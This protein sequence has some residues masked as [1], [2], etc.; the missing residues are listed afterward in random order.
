MISLLL[1]A[2]AGVSLEN[3]NVP[4]GKF[5]LLEVLGGGQGS[6]AGRIVNDETAKAISA[7]WS[8]VTTISASVGSLPLR[9]VQYRADMRTKDL[10][11]DHPLVYLL[12][13]ES[14]PGVSAASYKES[15]MAHLLLRGNMV[16]DAVRQRLSRELEALFLLDP[17]RYTV[18]RAYP[19]S[20]TRY[21]P[22]V[23]LHPTMQGEEG[24]VLGPGRTFRISGVGGDGVVG[25]SVIKYGRET[26]GAALG[27]EDYGARFFANDATPRGVLQHP[28]ALSKEAKDA[29]RNHWQGMYGGSHNSHRV[30]VLEEGMEFQPIQMNAEDTQFMESR[31]FTVREVARWFNIPPHKIADMADAK[32]ANIDAQNLEYLQDTL[33]PWLTRWRQA[34]TAQLLDDDERGR[35]RLAVEWDFRDL[36]RGDVAARTA[37]YQARFNTGSITPNEIR[38]EE[39]ENPLEGGDQAFVQRQYVPLDMVQ[40]VTEAGLTGPPA[41]PPPPAGGQD[42]GGEEE[43]QRQLL[44]ERARKLIPQGRQ[45]RAFDARLSLREA[46][47]PDFR[48]RAGRMVRG[49]LRELRK[50]KKRHL[51]G[52]LVDVPAWLESVDE[53]YRGGFVPFATEQLAAGFQAYAEAVRFQ[54][55]DEAPEGSPDPAPTQ[56]ELREFTEGYTEAAVNGIAAGGRRR[57]QQLAEQAQE[58]EEDPAAAVEQELESWAGDE[59]GTNGRAER[60]ATRHVNELNQAVAGFI[61]AA[62]NVSF[63]VA[64]TVGDSCP[65]CNAIDGTRVAP[66]ASFFTAGDELQPE[67]VNTPLRFNST[68]RHPPFHQG[69]DCVITPEL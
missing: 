37:Y 16:T 6:A 38:M 32:W 57:M 55:E 40:K 64:R 43:D 25:W 63:L 20:S 50:L 46:F 42:E 29:L 18:K 4:L 65:Y 41:A 36:L 11:L 51:E 23:L 9:V 34:I 45:R 7:V 53:Y 60:V 39:G 8:A 3:P 21:I 47:R 14:S 59:E 2:R 35:D 66:G 69:C 58:R 67:G 27:Q 49:E 15:S 44:L 24:R 61:W 5:S 22:V 19:V 54:A 62:M 10:V 33:T 68:V 26:F 12:N 52:D 13:T 30:A 1:E 56:D 28:N 17:D 31:R 48:E